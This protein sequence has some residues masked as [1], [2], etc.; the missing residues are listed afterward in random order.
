M[1]G[2]K[3]WAIIDT[4]KKEHRFCYANEDK[5]DGA[6]AFYDKKPIIKKGWKDK[7][8]VVRITIDYPGDSQGN[9]SGY[10]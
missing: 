5:K 1:N 7:K 3:L 6:M 8:I 4:Q 9:G 2:I 10:F